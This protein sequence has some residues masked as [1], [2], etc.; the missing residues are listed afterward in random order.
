[1]KS[2]LLPF[3]GAATAL[4]TPFSPDGT[5]DFSALERLIEFQIGGGI[6]ALVILGTTGESS[7]LSDGERR[8]VLHAASRSIGGRVPMIAG[9]GSCDTAHSAEL[10]KFACAE[11]ASGI[12][13]VTPYYIKT[14]PDGLTAHFSAIADV[15]EAP[16]ILYNVP[17]RT[18]TSIP[19]E[20]YRRLSAHPNI[21]G[22]KEASGDVGETL[23]LASETELSVY[24]GNDE[25]TVPIYAAGGCGVIS[26]LSNLIPAEVAGLCRMLEAGDFPSARALA[27]R[28]FPLIRALFSEGNPIPVKAACGMLG[29]CGETLRLPLVPMSADK[30]SILRERLHEVGLLS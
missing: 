9:I 8:A 10:T 16:V 11:G 17:S 14:T 25:L 1:M 24:C 19:H 3:T 23:F 21:V 6:D 15:S 4:V 13:A 26:V 30:R 7:T 29:L 27:L 5:V 12:L 20:V 28:Q 2:D 18:G 22:V